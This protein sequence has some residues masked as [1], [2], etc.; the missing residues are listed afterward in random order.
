M[1]KRVETLTINQTL[2]LF[3]SYGVKMSFETLCAIVDEAKVPWAVSARAGGAG[4]YLRKIFRKPLVEWLDSM[5]EEDNDEA[6]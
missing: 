4:P 2:D 1:A 6:V 5:A 3:R